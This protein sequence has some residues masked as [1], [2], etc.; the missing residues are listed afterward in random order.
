MSK[1]ILRKELAHMSTAQLSEIILDAYDARP[2][3]KEYFEFFLNPDVDKLNDKY[4]KIIN[5]EFGRVH[6]GTSKARV[7]VLKKCVREFAAYNP[8]VDAVYNFMKD[9][10][11]KLAAV[12]RLVNFTPAQMR[13]IQALATEMVKYG[14]AN[15]MADRAIN[16]AGTMLNHPNIS[17]AVRLAIAEGVQAAMDNA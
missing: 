2:E 5:K 13:Y 1:S 17:K 7:T 12:E 11:M 6:W 9:L 16:D 14:N 8:G 3:F 10:L 15:E 4:S